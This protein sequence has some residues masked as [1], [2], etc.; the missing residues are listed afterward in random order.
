MWNQAT[1]STHLCLHFTRFLMDYLA[2][3]LTADL[4]GHLETN[5]ISLLLVYTSIILGTHADGFSI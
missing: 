4:R 2:G 3:V 5:K 1:K